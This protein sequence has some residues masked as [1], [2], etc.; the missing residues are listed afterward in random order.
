MKGMMEANST[1]ACTVCGVVQPDGH[2]CPNCVTTGAPG[3]ILPVTFVEDVD[4]MVGKVLGER[5]RV[6]RILGRGGM[7]TVYACTQLVVERPVAIK[8][9]PPISGVAD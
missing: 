5:Y 9:L 1:H 3:Q 7:G 4:P 2:Q 8:V 6:E